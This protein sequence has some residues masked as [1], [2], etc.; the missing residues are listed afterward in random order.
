MASTWTFLLFLCPHLLATLYSPIPDCDEV[1]NYWEASHYLNHGYGLQTWEYSPIYGIRSWTYAGLHAAIIALFKNI[2]SASRTKSAEFYFLRLV[3]GV[4][5]A[6][7]ETKLHRTI[8]RTLSPRIATIFMLIMTTSTGL[9]HASTAYLPSTFA[10]YTTMLGT[11]SFM[12]W[13]RGIKTAQGITWF[14]IGAL[15]GWPFAAALVLPFILMEFILSLY[16][17]TVVS[18][19]KRS[20]DGVARSL[21][22]LVSNICSSF[23]TKSYVIRRPFRRVSI[24]SFTRNCFV[25]HGTL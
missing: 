1:F 21:T 20:L 23:T 25:C 6:I 2:S 15:L 9:F 19:I 7:C 8:S 22:V 16:G 3:L 14:A 12:D 4:L 10:M 17:S 11:A 5:C 18:L 13:T 24:L